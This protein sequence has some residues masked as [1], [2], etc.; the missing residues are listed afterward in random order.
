MAG[1]S[2]AKMKVAPKKPKLP[3]M[4]EV[5]KEAKDMFAMTVDAQIK[6][7]E[8]VDNLMNIRDYLKAYFD[9]TPGIL[10]CKVYQGI[11]IDTYKKV[12]EKVDEFSLEDFEK[13]TIKDY[14]EDILIKPDD[15]KDDNDLCKAGLVFLSVQPYGNKLVKMHQLM[16]DE[17]AKRKDA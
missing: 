15:I 17:I 9:E 7:A 4:E 3:P 13:E 1:K 12:R 2:A 6:N 5:F 11:S 16:Q 8:R 10:A 14:F